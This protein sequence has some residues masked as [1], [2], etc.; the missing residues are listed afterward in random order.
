MTVIRQ[1]NEGTAEWE[2]IAVGQA[3]P[4]GVT[5]PSGPPG[6]GQSV[7][8]TPP[9]SPVEGDQWFNSSLGRQ[10]VYYDGFWVEVGTSTR[11][12][13]GIVASA[14]APASTDVL[15]LDTDEEADGYYV[16]AG[17]STS[18]V[19]TKSSATDYDVE[20]QTPAITGPGDILPAGG[21]VGQLLSKSAGGDYQTSW[22]HQ[23]VDG[24]ALSG[25]FVV[26]PYAYSTFGYAPSAMWATL[27]SIPSQ[28]TVTGLAVTVLTGAA[29]TIGR[30]GLY[31]AL[32]NSNL[33]GALVVDAGTVDL[34]S[35]GQKEASCSAGISPGLYWFVLW[36]TGSNSPTLYGAAQSTYSTG[37]VGPFPQAGHIGGTLLPSGFRAAGF[38]ADA[39][40]PTSFPLGTPDLQRYAIHGAVRLTLS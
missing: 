29:S 38:T 28:G 35:S 16:P 8:T 31:S 30:L 32:P 11:G 6:P 19:L 37:G 25:H 1:Y 4:Q 7:G 12:E 20:W 21:N 24:C 3:G 36:I 39:P 2:T 34:S 10:F 5:G 40:L 18:Q 17:G 23:R 26:T 22:A 14:S 9:G 15:W 33:P 27:M 13:P